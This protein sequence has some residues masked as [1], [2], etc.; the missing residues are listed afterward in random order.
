[1]SLKADVEKEVKEIFASVWKEREGRTVPDPEDLSLNNDAMKLHATV[2]YADMADSTV[3]VDHYKPLFAAEMY[4]AY[5]RCAARII[6]NRQGSITAY[7][8]DRIMAVFLG[9]TKETLAVRAAMEIKY[10]VHEIINPLMKKYYPNTNYE[11]KHVVGVDTSQLY[12]A[13]IGVKN[14]NDLVWV[15]RAAN[16]AAK[17]CSLKET[18]STYIT[19]AVFDAMDKSVKYGGEKNELMWE[20]RTW[21]AQ[22]NM[23]IYRSNWQWEM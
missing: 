9:D 14:D 23:R 1:M 4:K 7:D 19:G 20:Q 17:L 15:G 12:V 5:L 11:L 13:R 8:G 10:A 18:Y 2:L 16:Y 6:K 3:L 21:T 22:N